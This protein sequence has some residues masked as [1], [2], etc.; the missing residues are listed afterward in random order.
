MLPVARRRIPLLLVTGGAVI[1]VLGLLFLWLVPAGPSEGG[2]VTTCIDAA[3]EEDVCRWTATADRA[4]LG[5]AHGPLADCPQ[6]RPGDRGRCVRTLQRRLRELGVDIPTTGRFEQLTTA[7]V[8]RVQREADPPITDSGIVGLRTQLA[9]EKSVARRDGTPHDAA[10]HGLP[11]RIVAAARQ[12][13]S[14]RAPGW[15]EESV[16]YVWGGGH[17]ARPGPTTGTCAG[18]EGPSP[19]RATSVRGL[20]CSGFT[21][22]IVALASGR[23]LLG[24]GNTD[25]QRAR[26]SAVDAPEPGDLVLFGS[27]T[28]THHVAVYIGDGRIIHAPDT[29][30]NVEIGELSDFD[31]VTGFYRVE[32]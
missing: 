20:D 11:S 4:P 17:A 26:T 18:Y 29:G 16:P 13:M 30:R 10:G 5:S 12:V 15:G 32:R 2:D 21:R 22:Y 27:V 14:G 28:D 6:L 8:R 9:I 3:G 1:T 25:D 19:C 7:A 24:P 23:D 31:D